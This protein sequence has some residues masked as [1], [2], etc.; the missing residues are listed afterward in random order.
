[1]ITDQATTGVQPRADALKRRQWPCQ[2]PER[3]AAVPFYQALNVPE[4]KKTGRACF[5]FTQERVY[6]FLPQKNT[7]R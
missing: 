6:K 3:A 4:R 1:M 2:L 5:P 7:L